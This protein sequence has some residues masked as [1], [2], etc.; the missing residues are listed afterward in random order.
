MI[1]MCSQVGLRGTGWGH[2]DLGWGREQVDFDFDF[3]ANFNESFYF[4]GNRSTLTLTFTLT[5]R[6][7]KEQIT[8]KG[9]LHF[10]LLQEIHPFWKV[11]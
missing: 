3:N 1:N 8:I 4:N 2:G 11:Q 10:L 6:S 7:S 9:P 5:G